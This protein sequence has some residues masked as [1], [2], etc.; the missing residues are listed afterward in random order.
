MCSLIDS[1]DF[2]K[3]QE[4]GTE[5]TAEAPVSGEKQRRDPPATDAATSKKKK[6]KDTDDEYE[7]DGNEDED[8]DLVADDDDDDDKEDTKKA[9]KNKEDAID[10]VD[11]EEDGESKDGD[12]EDEDED[13]GED[14]TAPPAV[15]AAVPNL[16]FISDEAAQSTERKMYDNNLNWGVVKKVNGVLDTAYIKF[17]HTRKADHPS[18]AAATI[19]MSNK[20]SLWRLHPKFH[21]RPNE[22]CKDYHVNNKVVKYR[23][24]RQNGEAVT[25]RLYVV[26]MKNFSS[27]TDEQI[28]KCGDIIVQHLKDNPKFF[29]NSIGQEGDFIQRNISHCDWIGEFEALQVLKANHGHELNATWGTRNPE[30]LSAYFRKGQLPSAYAHEIGAPRDWI[31]PAQRSRNAQ[32][33]AN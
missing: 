28:E 30:K 6:K 7:D 8:E 15:A 32:N 26:K 5:R 18:Y 22:E 21:I 23:V 13:D 10:L 3:R 16:D 9:G 17:D 4:E 33:N 27:F 19:W 31:K 12:Y 29:S 14:E 1:L 2:W 20:D 24:T 25:Q 11:T